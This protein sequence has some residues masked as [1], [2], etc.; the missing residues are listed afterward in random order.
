MAVLDTKIFAL[1][2]H[3]GWPIPIF[4][5]RM[6]LSKKK[7]PNTRKTS[8]KPHQ[9]IT[10]NSLHPSSFL[11]FTK[12]KNTVAL[13]GRSGIFVIPPQ[14]QMYSYFGDIT[15]NYKKKTNGACT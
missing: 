5:S 6:N 7:T 14:N 10:Y 2:M 11:L 4:L 1:S 15:I 8:V 9:N 12:R 13:L 3:F